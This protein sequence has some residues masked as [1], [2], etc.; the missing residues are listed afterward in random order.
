[1]VKILIINGKRYYF[2]ENFLQRGLIRGGIIDK[3][4][5]EVYYKGGFVKKGNGVLLRQSIY[6][7]LIQGSIV[8]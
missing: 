7:I 3:E 8:F 1:M 6:L 5:G 2:F 4:R